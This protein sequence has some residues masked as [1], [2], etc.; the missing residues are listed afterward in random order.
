MT[1][2]EI[3]QIAMNRSAEDIG[4]RADDFLLSDNVTV[5][6]CLGTNARKYLKEPITCN[7]V[8]YGNN[9]VA[10]VTDEV[11]GVV[12]E[13]IGRYEFYHCFETPNMQW[14]NDRLME[15]GHR[16]CFMAILPSRCG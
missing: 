4:C 1:N 3:L 6:F 9:V 12:A 14:L 2:R 8:S 13:Y 16:I 10:A 7:F 11:A 5:P 15:K